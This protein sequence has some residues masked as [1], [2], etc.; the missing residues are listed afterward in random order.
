M[1]TS[2][3]E[4]L[5]YARG[6]LA[7]HSPSASLDAEIL[8]GDL[9]GVK[10]TFLYTYPEKELTLDQVRAYHERI[11][12]RAHGVPIAYLLGEREFWSLP[13][14]VTPDT[15]IPRPETELLVA[16]TLERLADLP[17]AT[18]LDLGTGSGAV[19]LA[20]AMERPQWTII[21]TDVSVAALR[22]AQRNAQRY[23]RTNLHFVA[24]NWFHAFAPQARFDL[25][26]SNPPYIADNDP[27]VHQGD[28]RFEPRSALCSG[29]T[30][31]DDLKKIIQSAPQHLK[32]GAY[33][34]LEH[35]YDQHDA[36]QQHLHHHGYLDCRSWQDHQQHE[37]ISGGRI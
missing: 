35:G 27:H 26:L 18:I 25:I 9:L 2:I 16:L 23:E 7:A 19:A 1:T 12:T 5:V 29:S 37:R 10:R 36:V 20:L 15:L 13:I 3:H 17:Q 21:A 14:H 6:Q 8:L 4:A 24:S 30:G 22:V 28:L 33:L 11:K 34:L 31:L 32:P